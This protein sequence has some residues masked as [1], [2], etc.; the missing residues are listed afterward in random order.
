MQGSKHFG[1]KKVKPRS[2]RKAFKNSF[3][4]R[5]PAE[6]C[7]GKL[8][9]TAEQAA[10]AAANRRKFGKASEVYRCP[11]CQKFH[12]AGGTARKRHK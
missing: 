5:S 11:H 7:E 10:K 9:Y 1:F 2:K 4:D 12:I 3:P 8:Q 6:S